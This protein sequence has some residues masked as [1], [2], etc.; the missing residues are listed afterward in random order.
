MVGLLWLATRCR[1]RGAPNSIVEG[2]PFA[3]GAVDALS[4]VSS[5]SSSG[6]ASTTS[7]CF[8][9]PRGLSGFSKNQKDWTL[10]DDHDALVSTA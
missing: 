1:Q 10:M 6:K 5:T 8:G 9:A 2:C 4:R 7:R 3:V